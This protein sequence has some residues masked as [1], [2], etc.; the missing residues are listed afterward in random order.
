MTVQ[1]HPVCPLSYTSYV[2]VR[3]VQEIIIE[4][5]YCTRHL[6]DA[7]FYFHQDRIQKSTVEFLQMRKQPQGG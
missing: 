2:R 6:A 3:E 4:G 7:T 5:R 1:G